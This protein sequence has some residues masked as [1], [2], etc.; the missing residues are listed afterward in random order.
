MIKACIFDLDGT[1]ADTVESIAWSCNEA[2]A[3]CGLGPLPVKDYQYYAGDGAKVLVERALKAAGDGQLEHFE[4]VYNV[5]SEFFRRDCTYKVSVFDGMMGALETMKQ[6]GIRLAVLSNK[7]HDRAVDVVNKLFGE[8]YFDMVQ[9]QT[10][11]IPRKPSPIGALKIAEKFGVRPDQCMY[12]GDTNTDMQTG[13]N[14]KMTTVGVVWGFRG[15]EELAAFHPEYL[16]EKPEEIL[17]VLE[18]AD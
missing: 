10:D 7:P 11:N 9:G 8:N 14:A 16:I 5:Y 2:L 15:R 1:L 3:V 6:R 18:E 17:R 13:K 12:V 4:K